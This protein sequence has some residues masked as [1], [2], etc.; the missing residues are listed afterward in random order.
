MATDFDILYGKLNE[1]QQLAVNT[2]EGPVMVIAGPGTGKTQIL[3]ARILNILRLTDTKPEEILCLT[4]TESGAANMRQRLTAFLGPD[5]YKVHIFTF[6]GLCNRIIQE[7]QEK[8]SQRELRVMDEM[9]KLE[10]LNR[11]IR[12]LPAN[13]PIKNYQ[14]DPGVLRRQLSTLF[15]LMQ[16]EGYTVTEIRSWAEQLKQEE[17]FKEAFPDLVYKRAYKGFAAGDIKKSDYDKLTSAWEKLTAAAAEYPKYQKLKAD[18]GVYE[19][20]DMLD[21]VSRAFEEDAELLMG[22]QERFQYVLA[23]EYQDTSGLQNHILMQLISYWDENP[24]CFVVGDDDQSIYAFQGARVDNMLAFADKYAAN[25]KTIVLT[26]N[27]RSTQNILNAA[28]K[29][30]D[31]NQQRLVNKLS[32]LTKELVAAGNLETGTE[33]EL[34]QYRNRFAEAIGVADALERSHQSG[35]PWNEHAVIYSKHRLAEDLAEVLKTRE[36]PFV[37]A[38]DIDVLQEPI[39]RELLKWLNYLSEELDFPHKGEHLIYALLHSPVYEIS[40]YE[41]AK[42][43][44]EIYALSSETKPLH[45]RD[46]FASL[47]RKPSQ[48]NLFSENAPSAAI[49]ALWRETEIWLK[50]AGMLTVPQ[51]IESIYAKGGF[52]SYALKHHN[53]E[54]ILEVLSSFMEFAVSRNERNPFMPLKSFIAEVESMLGAGIAIPLEKRLGNTDGVMLTTAHRAKGLEFEHVFII[55]GDQEAW[56]RDRSNALPFKIAALIRGMRMERSNEQDAEEGFEERRRLFYVAMTRAKSRLTISCSRQKVDAKSSILIPSRFLIEMQ[57][58]EPAPTEI[59]VSEM[60]N[61]A[62]MV[63][64]HTGKPKLRNEQEAWLRKQVQGFRF[65]PTT[66]YTLFECGLKFYFQRIARVPSA[67]NAAA[68]YGTALHGALAKWVAAGTDKDHPQWWDAPELV[69]QFEN[70]LY[71]KRAAFSEESYKMRLQQG[72]DL[73]PLYH[74]ARLEEFQK[75]NVVITERWFQSAIDGVEIGGFADKLIFHGNDVVIVDYKSGNP[76]NAEKKFKVPTERSMEGKLPPPYWFQLGIYH[77]VINGISGKNWRAAMGVVDLLDK[78]DKGEFG[79]LKMTYSGEDLDL[80]REYV[81]EGKRKL[82]N[83]EFL[84]GCNNCEWCD[85]AKQTGQVVWVPAEEEV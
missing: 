13:S 74:A 82:E 78:N 81:K 47:L 43:S 48:G 25:L 41:I 1:E 26:S 55:S 57:E 40:P 50:E 58:N 66:L 67:P 83:L 10:I 19:F 4:Y 76:A 46:H 2:I 39:V 80:L 16:D 59:P 70:E 63:L 54:W 27:Y 73:L 6:H 11:L 8:F 23:D 85:F 51:L 62:E 33:P 38:K 35:I 37:L 68:A 34:L 44:S 17:H 49:S 60:A 21:W 56:E 64:M 65:A 52:L 32:F 84:Q 79:Q 14:E 28:K 3:A 18:A 15:D 53:R 61:V 72:R 22:Y 36:I 77:L 30:I 24:N 5:A 20:R 7:N 71:R 31:H 42:I 12:E 29:V 45:W 69:Y 9:E 75:E